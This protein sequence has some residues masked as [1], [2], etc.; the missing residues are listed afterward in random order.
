MTLPLYGID[1]SRVV[2]QPIR[3]NLYNDTDWIASVQN[4]VASIV[5]EASRVAIIG[6]NKDGSSWYLNMFPQWTLID[7]EL[8]KPL[9][10]TDIRDLLFREKF[11]A[12]YIHSVVPAAVMDMLNQFIRTE[13]YAQVIRERRFIEIYR[14]Q[15][16][17]LQYEPVFVT[18]DAVVVRSG[19]I[20]MVERRSEP[21]KGLMALPGGFL[22]ASTDKSMLDCAIRELREETKIKVPP[23]IL[24]GSVA[25]SKVFD[26]INR[27]ARGRTIT[28][29]F[30]FNLGNMRE[31]P[32]VKGTDDAK[33]A[34]W[35]PIS[36]ID[37]SKCFED[38]YDI[39]KF[40]T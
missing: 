12:E 3:D 11:N 9:D 25:D 26:A 2:I 28:H 27:S 19:H 4:T 30:H 38:H 16:E 13:E 20:L 21:G 17:G 39:I 32:K 40:F 33:V 7:V 15:F 5:D 23:A 8:I 6:H 14:K 31:F 10:A 1:N 35:V 22:N 24:R 18:A 29:A 36:E 34:M 37:S